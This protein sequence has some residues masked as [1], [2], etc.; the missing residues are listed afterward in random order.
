MKK[1][2]SVLLLLCL[3]LGCFAACNVPEKD[4][5]GSSEQPSE[6]QS[7]SS[8]ESGLKGNEE[9]LSETETQ[10]NLKKVYF[11]KNNIPGTVLNY[12]LLSEYDY[13]PLDDKLNSFA[14]IET[15]AD[16]LQLFS[17][18]GEEH[19]LIKDIDQVD[20]NQYNVIAVKAVHTSTDSPF[21]LER[22]LLQEGRLVF[23]F[24]SNY[25][26]ISTEDYIVQVSFLLVKKSDCSGNISDAFLCAYST[27]SSGEVPDVQVGYGLCLGSYYYEFY[28]EYK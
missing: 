17:E 24:Q 7:E 23:V 11:S 1:Y 20:F 10:E 12:T 21:S 26:G 28:Y 14:L 9:S 18:L 13:F 6:S 15:K 8:V 2:I 25:D 19:A 3:L 16:F 4:P 5:E 22:V 27:K